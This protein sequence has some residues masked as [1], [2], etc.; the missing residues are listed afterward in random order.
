MDKLQN[1]VNQLREDIA[2]IESQQAGQAKESLAAKMAL[3]EAEDEVAGVQGE[4]KNLYNQWE[5]CL[6]GMSRRDDSYRAMIDALRLVLEPLSFLAR[7]Y[8]SELFFWRNRDYFKTKQLKAKKSH[9]PTLS[10]QRCLNNLL[11]C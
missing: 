2:L 10:K 1:Q 5:V 9:A 6:L 3:A 7:A 8:M 4:K 11:G